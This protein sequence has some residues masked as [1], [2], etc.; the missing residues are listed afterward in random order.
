[1]PRFTVLTATYNREKTLH[2]VYDSLCAQTYKDFEWLVV[3]DGSQDGTR[4]VLQRWAEKADF[5]IRYVYQDNAG[6]HVA[7]NRGVQDARGELLIVLD[8]DDGCVPEALERLAWHWDSIPAKR[9]TGFAGVTVLCVDQYG[10]RIGTPFPKDRMDSDALEI[11]YRYKVRGEKWGFNRTEILRLYPFPE[12]YQRTYIP[13]DIVWNQIARKY[14]TRFVNEN[15]RI[16]WIE[17]QSM[18]HGQEAEKNAIGGC[19]EH[20]YRLNNEIDW[21]FYAPITFLKSAV[22]YGRFSFHLGRGPIGQFTSL[23]RWPGRALWLLA[24]VPAFFA[25][26]RDIA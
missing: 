3:D 9:R 25:Y 6:K 7:F 16:Y 8:S 20:M 24:M 2:R 26:K 10:N 17:G 14:K 22:H 1:M 23:K 21:F 13:E 19:M 15:L 5:P 12:E 11:R 4:L 18:V